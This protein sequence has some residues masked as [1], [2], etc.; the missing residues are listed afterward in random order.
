M[1]P[2]SP[3]ITIDGPSGSGK[4][5]V[6][7]AL[8]NAL[9][10][11]FLDSGAL[12]RVVAYA[13][14]KQAIGLDNALQ[15]AGLAVNLAIRFE[16]RPGGGEPV[17]RLEDEDI[18]L[19]IRAENCGHAAS[20]V[21]ALPEVRQALLDRQRAFRTTPGLVA[22]GRD[23]GTLVFPDAELKF[24]LTA[25]TAERAQRRYK[26]LKQKGMS[27]NLRSL[28]EDIEARDKRDSERR[29][30]PLTV[31][32]DA[33]VVDTTGVDIDSVVEHVMQVVREHNLTG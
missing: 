16:S 2:G 5:T 15:L 22:D 18:S 30:S 20:K 8:A 25:S 23:M 11:R 10:W 26:Q 24:F 21:A 7:L 29:T 13:A 32:K 1:A 28:L 12:Y 33:M 4:G 17:V 9:G 27:V 31:A 14:Q 19:A 3:V 6:G